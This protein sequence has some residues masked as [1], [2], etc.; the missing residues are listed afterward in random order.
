MDD[1]FGVDGAGVQMLQR[2][3]DAVRFGLSADEFVFEVDVLVR[4]DPALD[5]CLD[6]E[7]QR[8]ECPGGPGWTAVE[9]PLDRCCDG[10]ALVVVSVAT[11]RF[12]GRVVG[13]DDAFQAV[14]FV[15]FAGV[16]KGGSQ[17]GVDERLAARSGRGRVRCRDLS[18][19]C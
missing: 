2:G 16:V 6:G 19:R 17:R 14:E 5:V 18:A 11:V 4:E 9:E 7:L 8:G 1:G 3:W 15:L 12:S 13:G 10:V